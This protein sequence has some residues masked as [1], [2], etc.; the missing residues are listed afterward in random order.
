MPEEAFSEM[1]KVALKPFMPEKIATGEKRHSWMVPHKQVEK[2]RVLLNLE[3]TTL[4]QDIGII[5][6][7]HWRKYRDDEWIFQPYAMAIGYLLLVQI[8]KQLLKSNTALEKLLQ[9]KPVVNGGDFLRE[10]PSGSQAFKQLAAEN[11]RLKADID[12]RQSAIQLL[13]DEVTSL[14]AALGPDARYTLV[15]ASNEKAN[16][17]EA[18]LFNQSIPSVKL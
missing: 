2:I 9:A 10:E 15:R 11:K 17:L 7:G 4:M 8:C 16:V 5:G 18:F 3:Y 1:V 12:V 13:Q 6:T 14:R